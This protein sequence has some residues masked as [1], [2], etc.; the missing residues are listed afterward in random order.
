MKRLASKRAKEARALFL[1]RTYTM[2]RHM[3][4]RA[5]EVPTSVPFSL[6]EL[7]AEVEL[8]LNTEDGPFGARDCRYCGDRLKPKTFSLDHRIPVDRGGSWDL[9][10]LDV[11]C[12]KCNRAK[13][14]MTGEE[15]DAVLR[16][17]RTMPERTMNDV[18]GR[19]KAGAA[20]RRLTL[21]R[22]KAA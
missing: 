14:T 2:Y 5:D 22:R 6:D 1:R 15:F 21:V 4:D 18:L 8:H 17:L 3:A 12:E 16:V 13:G 10:N 20:L 7:R 19:L 11:I 9:S